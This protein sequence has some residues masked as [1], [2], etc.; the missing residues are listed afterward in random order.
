MTPIIEFAGL[1]IEYIG[2]I[3]VII[4]IVI[5]L[6]RLF[7]KEYTMEHVRHHLA[8][9]IMFGIEFIIAADILLVTVATNV[10]EIVQLGGIVVIRVLL[11]YALS[12]EAKG[13]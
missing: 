6:V 7:S 11:G 9:R 4:S 8:K 1:L 2:I 5:A 3:I 12:K 10:T 13:K